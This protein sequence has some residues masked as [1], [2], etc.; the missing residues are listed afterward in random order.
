MNSL[1]PLACVT[2]LAAMVFALC[3]MLAVRDGRNEAQQKAIEALADACAKTLAERDARIDS[4]ARENSRLI[5][6][7]RQLMGE[8]IVASELI[9]EW[10][11]MIN[12]R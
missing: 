8:P 1:I 4:L 5:M 6:R 12:D 3:Y 11:E 7:M 10:E 2:L 9:A